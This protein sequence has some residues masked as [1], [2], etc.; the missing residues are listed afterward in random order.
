[1]WKEKECRDWRS[2]KPVAE[3]TCDVPAFQTRDGVLLCGRHPGR[4]VPVGDLG[5]P[6]RP[7]FRCIACGRIYFEKSPGADAPGEAT[8]NSEEVSDGKE[9]RANNRELR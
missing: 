2:A 3:I 9:E 4:L 7:A 5:H 6:R 8:G 1:M